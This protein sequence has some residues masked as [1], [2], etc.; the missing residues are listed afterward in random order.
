MHVCITWDLQGIIFYNHELDLQTTLSSVLYY[1][2]LFHHWTARPYKIKSE[3]NTLVSFH[4]WQ[5]I[6]L[7]L[8]L[9]N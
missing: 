9:N 4:N 7:W 5:K 6:E 2:F 3:I 8:D 1:A